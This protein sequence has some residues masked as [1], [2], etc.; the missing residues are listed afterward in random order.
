MDILRKRRPVR[1][2][3]LLDNPTRGARTPPHY[4]AIRSI[5]AS[6]E[7][8]SEGNTEFLKSGKGVARITASGIA[9]LKEHLS[10][11]GVSCRIE[12]TA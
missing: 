10:A 9:A 6:G 12:V 7:S 3:E 2:W 11:H 4:D 8:S 5:V 1:D